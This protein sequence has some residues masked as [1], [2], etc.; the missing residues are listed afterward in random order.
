VAVELH[1]AARQFLGGGRGA[2]VRTGAQLR[3]ELIDPLG[4]HLGRVRCGH[5]DLQLK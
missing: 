2:W 1:Q 4:G 5:R 3:Q